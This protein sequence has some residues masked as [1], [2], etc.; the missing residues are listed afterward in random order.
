MCVSPHWMFQFFKKHQVWPLHETEKTNRNNGY[1]HVSPVHKRRDFCHIQ[2]IN[3]AYFVSFILLSLH[4]LNTQQ[5]IFSKADPCGPGANVPIC[6]NW[7]IQDTETHVFSVYLRISNVAIWH[8]W[9]AWKINECFLS[10]E[11]LGLST[12]L[13]DESLNLPFTIT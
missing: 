9:S 2:I 3:A 1:Q 12:S 4:R 8:I 10:I 11:K 13:N 7:H 6:S 5:R